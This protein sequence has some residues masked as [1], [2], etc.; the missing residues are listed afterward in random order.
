[1][2]VVLDGTGTIELACRPR[3]R[4]GSGASGLPILPLEPINYCPVLMI[5]KIWRRQP[6]SAGSGCQP[7]VRVR[8]ANSTG[9]LSVGCTSFP[10]TLIGPDHRVVA[11]YGAT[12]VG[13]NRLIRA[14]CA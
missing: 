8:I 9:V 11:N 6:R 10:A 7:K 5:N 3:V 4:A 14:G 1:M 2:V 13:P 12:V